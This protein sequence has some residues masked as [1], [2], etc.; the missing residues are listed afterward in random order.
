[1]LCIFFLLKIEIN[2]WKKKKKKKWFKSM[3]VFV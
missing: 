1:M 3:Y 2:S